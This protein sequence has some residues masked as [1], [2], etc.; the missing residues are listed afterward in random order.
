[1]IMSDLSDTLEELLSPEG[2]DYP[3]LN[4]RE[5]DNNDITAHSFVDRDKKVLRHY[6]GAAWPARVLSKFLQDNHKACWTYTTFHLQ[7]ALQ[8]TGAPTIAIYPDISRTDRVKDLRKRGDKT[9]LVKKSGVEV[10]PNVAKNYDKVEIMDPMVQ[11]YCELY[12]EDLAKRV[13]LS[14]RLLSPLLTTHILL[15]PMFGLKS[16][17]VGAGLLTSLQYE[18]AKMRELQVR[19]LIFCTQHYFQ[20]CSQEL[21]HIHILTFPFI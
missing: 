14:D 13:G 15:N 7:L 21:T 18:K 10:D 12:V 2:A 5:R 1:M 9:I 4:Q 11:C 20:P 19:I 16:R 3:L 6:E 8:D 17:I